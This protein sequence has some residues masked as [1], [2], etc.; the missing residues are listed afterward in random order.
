V[1]LRHWSRFL[2]PGT[3]T[4]ALVQAD[5]YVQLSHLRL[6]GKAITYLQWIW[7]VDKIYTLTGNIKY[8]PQLSV[9]IIFHCTIPKILKIIL[10]HTCLYIKLQPEIDCGNPL[11]ITWL[12]SD[13][14]HLSG[15]MDIL[16]TLGVQI[17]Y[18]EVSSNA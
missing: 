12:N 2:H 4:P 10:I 3:G 6:K 18:L 17:C 8:I 11:L 9:R 1:Y 13:E 7:N 5:A 14:L 16:A 15:N